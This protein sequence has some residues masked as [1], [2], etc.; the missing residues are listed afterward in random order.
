MGRRGLTSDLARAQR[1]TPA[2]A[3]AVKALSAER[4]KPTEADAPKLSTF[5]G[6]KRKPLE[7]QLTLGA[8]S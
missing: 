6:A 1:L 3:E 7:G 4:R 8:D 2:Q 5:P